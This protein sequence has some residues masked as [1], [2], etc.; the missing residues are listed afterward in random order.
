MTSITNR[1]VSSTVPRQPTAPVEPQAP[2]A[3]PQQAPEAQPTSQVRAERERDSFTPAPSPLASLQPTGR[4]R[5]STQG[6]NFVLEG[7]AGLGGRAGT[8]TGG[9]PTRAGTLSAGGSASVGGSLRVEVP[10]QG[11]TDAIRNGEMP[12]PA[13]PES[14]PVG[15]RATAQVQGQAAGNVGLRA[16]PGRLGQALGLSTS[17]EGQHTQRY[18]VQRVSPETVRATVTSQDRQQDATSARGF[19]ARQDQ[20]LERSQSADFNITTPEGRGA[21]QDFLRTGQLP[22]QDGPGVTNARSS[23]SLDQNRRLT[24]ADRTVAAA[25]N[26][27]RI[28]QDSNG[29]RVQQGERN[30]DGTRVNRDVRVG[31]DNTGGQG[32][33]RINDSVRATTTAR[34]GQTPETTY[35]L[36]FSDPAAAQ[37]ARAAFTGNDDAGSAPFSVNLTEQQARQMVERTLGP[38]MAGG[39]RPM[40][41]ALRVL[42]GGGQTQFATGLYN[43]TLD[44]QNPTGARR[45]LQGTEGAPPSPAATPAFAPAPSLE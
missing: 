37:V 10:R 39:Q 33:T 25:G 45:P 34:P 29:Y 28:T 12:N 18:E 43:A 7:N 20:R 22:R 41:Q 11:A 17:L 32:E 31:N 15:T 2:V 4:M 27:T 9:V 36:T 35:S 42:S 23:D 19:G 26:D 40:E 1:P 38:D 44:Q 3:A 6:D 13:N 5:V 30:V 14:W 8:P 16:G 24:V 21:Y